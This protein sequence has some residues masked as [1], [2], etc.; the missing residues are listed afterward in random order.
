LDELFL[1][2][3]P[4]T[5]HQHRIPHPYPCYG[6]NRSTNLHQ[7][8]GEEKQKTFGTPPT[9]PRPTTPS[10]THHSTPLPKRLDLQ[11]PPTT[12]HPSGELDQH[13][14]A[15][16][17]PQRSTQDIHHGDRKRTNCSST[18]TYPRPTPR[19]PPHRISI[20]RSRLLPPH[21]RRRCRTLFTRHYQIEHHL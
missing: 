11:V 8:R 13:S 17:E 12:T 6:P 7:Q 1:Q 15:P 3:T 18:G 2:L 19:P 5:Q 16:V 9:S 21:P 10:R 4:N 14:K 20:H